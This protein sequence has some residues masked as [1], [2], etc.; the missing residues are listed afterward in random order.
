MN[1]RRHSPFFYLMCF[2]RSIVR[3]SANWCHTDPTGTMVSPNWVWDRPQHKLLR[4]CLIYGI[5][6]AFQAKPIYPQRE[7][8][9]IPVARRLGSEVWQNASTAIPL[10]MSS[11][12]VSQTSYNW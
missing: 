5:S 9:T 7:G 12:D 3:R 8:C 4:F 2:S 10:L 1:E 6:D 11:P